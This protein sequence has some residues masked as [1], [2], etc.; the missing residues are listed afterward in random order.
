LTIKVSHRFVMGS[1]FHH[2][3]SFARLLFA[4]QA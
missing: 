4:C 1:T 2:P 3:L